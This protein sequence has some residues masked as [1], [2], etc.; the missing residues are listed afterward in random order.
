[1]IFYPSDYERTAEATKTALKEIVNK[2]ERNG[3]VI[4]PES[5][6]YLARPQD[7]KHVIPITAQLAQTHR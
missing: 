6:E 7:P 5:L 4:S 3:R 2:E 1:M